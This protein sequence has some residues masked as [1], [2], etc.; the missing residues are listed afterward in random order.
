M[1][2]GGGG[3]TVGNYCSGVGVDITLLLGNV[4]VDKKVARVASC[5]ARVLDSEELGNRSKKS[6]VYFTL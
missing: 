4:C 3:G 6:Y 2:G 1:C 5:M